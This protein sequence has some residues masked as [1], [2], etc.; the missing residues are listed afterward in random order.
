MKSLLPPFFALAALALPACSAPAD[1]DGSAADAVT[2]EALTKGRAAEAKVAEALA[3][4]DLGQFVLNVEFDRF[5]RLTGCISVHGHAVAMMPGGLPS[6]RFV[7]VSGQLDVINTNGGYIPL[8]Y[9]SALTGGVAN[10]TPVVI[11]LVRRDW[12]VL[13]LTF[14][15][16]FPYPPS[17]TQRLDGV[18]VGHQLLPAGSAFEGQSHLAERCSWNPF[19]CS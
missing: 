15:I 3:E 1:D 13:R 11:D 14:V 2:D 18:A 4:I 19:D 6:V 8:Q 5:R 10:G 7:G 16:A 9:C 12:S 17:F